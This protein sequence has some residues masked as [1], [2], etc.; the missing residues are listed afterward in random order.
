MR[1][2]ALFVWSL[3][4]VA[5]SS[6]VTGTTSSDCAQSPDKTSCNACYAKQYPGGV[7]DYNAVATCVF[8]SACYTSCGSETSASFCA[9]PP[10]NMDECDTGDC[11]ACQKCSSTSSASCLGTVQFCLANSDCNALLG[12]TCP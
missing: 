5:C 3:A 2:W 6:S 9:G 1:A 8:C 7:S 4:L 12:A 10:P 11:A